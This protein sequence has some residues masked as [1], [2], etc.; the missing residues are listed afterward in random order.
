MVRYSRVV[1]GAV[2]FCAGALVLVSGI[3]S[4]KDVVLGDPYANA[5]QRDRIK[6]DAVQQILIAFR[7][8]HDRRRGGDCLGGCR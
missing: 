7:R 1:V 5:F 8:S 2:F 3:A 6:F 4:G